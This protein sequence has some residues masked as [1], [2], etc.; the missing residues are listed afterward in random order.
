MSAKILVVDDSASDRFIIER[1]L[2]EYD[3]LTACDGIEAMQQID[4]HGDIDIVILDLNMPKMDGFEVLKALKSNDRYKGLRTIILTNYDELDNEIEGLRLGAVDYIR[5]PVNMD[6]LKAR[7]EIHVELLRIQQML[8]QKLYEQGLTF[9]T[10]FQ[11]APIG[12]AISHGSEPSNGREN[13]V[14][15]FNPMFEKITGRTKD[16]LMELGW[17]KITYPDDLDKDLINF[18]KLQRGELSSYS[19]EKR[20][21]RPDGSIVW[22]QMTVAPL[23]ISNDDRYNH[24][25]LAQEITRRKEMEADLLES[26]RSKSVLLSHLPGLAYR[27]KYD[28]QWTMEFVSAGCSTLTGYSPESLINNKELAFCDLVAPEYRES[29]WIEWEKAIAKRMPLNYEYQIITAEGERKWVLEMGEGVFGEGGEV[30]ALEGIIIDITYRKRI[31]DRLKYNSEHD[32]W[33]GLHNLNYL[34]TLLERDGKH[35]RLENRA[36]VSTNLNTVQSLTATYGFHYTQELMREVAD[37]LG[38]Y[39]TDRRMLF[40]TYENLFVF[41][42]KDYKDREELTE[43]CRDIANMLESLLVAERIGGGIGVVQIDKDSDRDVDQLMKRLLIASEKALNIYDR[44]VG[45]CFY[46]AEIEMEMIREEEIKRELTKIAADENYGE[47]FLQ[48]QPILDLES[49]RICGFE[50][51][52]R[53]KIEKFGLVP[54]LEFIPIAEKTKLIVPIGRR[55]IIRALRFL[56]RLKDNGFGGVLVSINVSAIQLLRSDFSE[57]LFKMIDRTQVNRENIGLEITESVF[58]SNYEEINRIIGGL[59]DSGIQIAIDDFGTGYSSLAREREL[60]VN[61][62]KIDK[63]FIDKLMCLDAKNTITSDI[64]SMAHKLG[65]CVIAEGVEHEK[66]RQYLHSWGCDRIQGYLIGKPLDEEAAI[67]VLKASQLL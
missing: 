39:C 67:G 15:R 25:C 29:L 14:A 22:V 20:Y 62:L 23:I 4:E 38:Q 32:R 56:R 48:Y 26:E 46:D 13:T 50:A 12:I 35:R 21:V 55:A 8:E 27:C 52:S 34:E 65:H 28:R 45:I 30:E 43:F 44:D 61:C 17:A 9:D 11:Q 1:M 57:N 3:I 40:Y 41:Y 60:N 16:E 6:S 37:M 49:N 10:I 24:I 18:K 53:L 36:F 64:I 63:S 19:M 59:K 51:L 58:A 2:R 47:L 31:E 42:L 54:A 66:Q 7:I 5:K 33:T